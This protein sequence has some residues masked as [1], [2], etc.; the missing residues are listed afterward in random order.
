MYDD[1]ACEKFGGAIACFHSRLGFSDHDRV[2]VGAK[3]ESSLT[4]HA[5]Q[6]YHTTQKQDTGK[7]TTHVTTN[8]GVLGKR[9]P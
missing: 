7:S 6:P 3:R 1:V 2:H 9:I 5:K 4:L 8:V